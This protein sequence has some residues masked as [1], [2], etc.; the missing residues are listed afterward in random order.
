VP[1][2]LSPFVICFATQQQS[3]SP[4]VPV[5]LF[6]SYYFFLYFQ[7]NV[8]L[9]IPLCIVIAAQLDSAFCLF[10]RQTVSEKTE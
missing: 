9:F 3:F 8:P 6:A 1:L 10:G 2:A 5:A 4:A 7:A